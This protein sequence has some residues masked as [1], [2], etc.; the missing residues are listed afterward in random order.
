M[1]CSSSNSFISADTAAQKNAKRSLQEEEAEE[2]AERQALA[3]F[4]EAGL[5][6]VRLP[7]LVLT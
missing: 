3:E 6:C 7:V 2:Q 1:S 4:L 5:Y